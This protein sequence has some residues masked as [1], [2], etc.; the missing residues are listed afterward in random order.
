MFNSKTLWN[1]DGYEPDVTDK[2]Y[3]EDYSE[4]RS[5]EIEL[6]DRLWTRV[7]GGR[8]RTY[9]EGEAE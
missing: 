3:D 8:K 4:T 9:A 5:D 6:F 7:S 2:L 1:R